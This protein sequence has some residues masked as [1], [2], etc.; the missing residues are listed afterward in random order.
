MKHTSHAVIFVLIR[1][2]AL[3]ARFS[4]GF[5][6]GKEEGG[7]EGKE[8]VPKHIPEHERAWWGGGGGGGKHAPSGIKKNIFLS[9]SDKV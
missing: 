2:V 1:Q 9:P 7:R 4:T 3:C 8:K 6:H 5:F